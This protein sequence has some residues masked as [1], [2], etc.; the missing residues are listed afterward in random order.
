MQKKFRYV[1]LMIGLTLNLTGCFFSSSPSVL[2]AT[3][4]TGHFLNPNVYNH[5]S[6]VVVTFYQLKS[7]TIFQQV[8][9]F[10]LYGNAEKTLGSDLLDKY[11]LEVRP[12]KAQE[13]NFSLS[14]TVNFIGV[15]AAFRE[16][17]HTQ[18]RQ[19][20]PIKPGKDIH[21]Q[22]AVNAQSIMV[23]KK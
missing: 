13:I 23:I 18:W 9:F 2:N 15:V 1:L 6:P 8:N 11:E 22:V 16:P 5:S 4:E 19:V 7:E 10:S 20:I 17:D 21:L 12:E 3:V 14:P